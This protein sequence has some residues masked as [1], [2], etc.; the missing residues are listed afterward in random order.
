MECDKNH[1]NEATAHKIFVR[2]VFGGLVVNKVICCSCSYIS[3][4]TEGAFGL[5][6]PIENSDSLIGALQTHTET[7]V[8][9]FR[10]G[11]CGKKGIVQKIELE[12]LPP[13]FTFHLKR[14]DS[15]N[16]KIKKHL[17]FPPVI[18]L[19]PFASSDKVTFP[20]A[21]PFEMHLNY[22]LYAIVVHEGETSNAGHY[23]SFIRLN[24]NEWYRY[25]D[26]E[27]S[28][29][30]EEEVFKQMAY[31]LFYAPFGT[32]CFTDFIQTLQSMN[33]FTSLPVSQQLSS[34]ELAQGDKGSRSQADKDHIRPE[35]TDKH[36]SLTCDKKAADEGV[37]LVAKKKAA[38]GDESSISKGGWEVQKRRQRKRK[39]VIR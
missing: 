30:D 27:V 33:V 7:T 12:R 39:N 31:I 17:S 1:G 8:A 24:S 35:T 18:D 19:L 4:K 16:N 38:G 34:S 29:V 28:A 2:R 9:D 26:S 15:L 20:F 22:E 11:K 23:Y 14:F 37:S 10:C 25:D 5:Q 32:N 21:L 3:R 36:P 13:V 6:L